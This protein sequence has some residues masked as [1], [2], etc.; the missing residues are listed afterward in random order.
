MGNLLWNTQG[1]FWVDFDDM[2]MGPAIQDIWLLVPG[3][4]DYSINLREKLITAYNTI[5]SFN[6]SD[7]ELIEPLRALRYIHFSAWI[8]KRYE[9]QSFQ[10]VFDEFNTWGYWNMQ[11]HDLEE[12][13]SLILSTL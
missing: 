12:Q 8:K 5:R 10:R 2:L 6:H 4:D 3:R 9:D 11:V 1:L 13:R 7:L